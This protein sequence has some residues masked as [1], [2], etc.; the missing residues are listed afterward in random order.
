MQLNV[1]SKIG[2]LLTNWRNGQK[3]VAKSIGNYMYVNKLNAY[4][5]L[6]D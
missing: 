2:F 5:Y 4:F 1:Y 3:V 6:G